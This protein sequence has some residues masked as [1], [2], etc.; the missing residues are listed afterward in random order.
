MIRIGRC[1]YD[2]QGKRTDPSYPGYTPVVVL[3]KGHNK[4]GVLGPYEL[5]DHKG[6]IMENVWQF[7]K[8]YTEVPATTQ[9]Y[10]RWDHRVIWKYPKEKHMINDEIQPAYWQ[11]REK[12]MNNPYAVRYPVGFGNMS[13]CLF[14]II[15]EDP[16]TRLDYIEARKEIYVP[17]YCKLVKEQDRFWE[18]KKMLDDGHKLLIIEV[19]GP[20]QESL[21]YYKETYGVDDSFIEDDTILA[22]EE[23]LCI[24]LNDKKHSFGHGYCLALALLDE[25]AG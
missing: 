18:L 19:D 1:K 21:D 16:E 25:V 11:W 23:N 2:R 7:S 22:T 15:D 14:S 9:Y 4:W 20:H 8:C 10:S 3:M 6:R 17:V 12:G 5:K 24:M 13:K